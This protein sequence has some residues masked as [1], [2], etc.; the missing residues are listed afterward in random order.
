MENRIGVLVFASLVLF[1][2]LIP[3][4]F[5]HHGN[6]AYDKRTVVVKG[7]ITEWRWTNPVL[8]DEDGTMHLVR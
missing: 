8:V 5:A 6:A 7:V 3:P 1:T 4:T 2:L